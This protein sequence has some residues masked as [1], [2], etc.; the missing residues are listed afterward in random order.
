MPGWPP[1]IRDCCG[2]L[3]LCPS[4]RERWSGDHGR[5]LCRRI[6][7]APDLGTKPCSARSPEGGWAT[8]PGW[9][10][11]KGRHDSEKED[12]S[13]LF[14]VVRDGASDPIRPAMMGRI[15]ALLSV[16]I[17]SLSACAAHGPYEPII[18]IDPGHGGVDPGAS[19]S[20]LL[21]KD[22]ALRMGLAL[23]DQLE[24]TGRYRVV[25]T[26][27][28]DRTVRLPDRLRIARQS[29]GELFISLHADSLISA[30]EVR[31]ASVYMPS[32]RGSS[33]RSAPPASKAARAPVLAR[34]DLSAQE[35]IRPA[36]NDQSMRLAELLE[37]ELHGATKMARRRPAPAKFV[38]LRSPDMPSVLIELGYLS[39]PADEK[40]LADDAHIVSL[41]IAVARAVDLYFG[42]EPS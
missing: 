39:N 17:L 19:G 34:I 23:R 12:E 10:R 38:V 16:L 11:N 36:I 8:S 37:Q 6:A 24:A 1:R 42:V 25:M 3:G 41:A 20:A 26:R 22:V 30:P 5:S 35:E 33:D 7:V 40:A 14:E 4:G 15:A 27:D 29:R 13:A 2:E 32:E 9:T 21:E 28:D 31:G 18:V